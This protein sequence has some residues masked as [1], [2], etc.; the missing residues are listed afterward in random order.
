MPQRSNIYNIKLSVRQF[1]FRHRPREQNCLTHCFTKLRID[2]I[3]SIAKK[4]IKSVDVKK[5]ALGNA[6]PGAFTLG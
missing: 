1:S 2:A 5:K 6:V 3:L 4:A